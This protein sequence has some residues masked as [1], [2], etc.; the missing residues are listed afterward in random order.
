M[1]RKMSRPFR[2]SAAA[3]ICFAMLSVECS[4]RAGASASSSPVQVS[5]TV[6]RPLQTERREI[7]PGQTTIELRNLSG[8]NVWTHASAFDGERIGQACTR[9]ERCRPI[10]VVTIEY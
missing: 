4:A 5:A 3:S 10:V 2:A 6:I 1:N 7:S 9:P 8:A